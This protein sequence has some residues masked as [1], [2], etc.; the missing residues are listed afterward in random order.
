MT[1]FITIAGLWYIWIE[2]HIVSVITGSITIVKFVFAAPF[3][4]LTFIL[5]CFI[6]W[7]QECNKYLL[8]PMLLCFAFLGFTPVLKKH[9]ETCL[10]ENHLYTFFKVNR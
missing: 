3:I 7:F 4:L 8:V 10:R 1:W 9:V 6:E 5:A 2:G